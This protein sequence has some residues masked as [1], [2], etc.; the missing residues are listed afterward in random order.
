MKTARL[1]LEDG[2]LLEGKSFG[3]LATRG[4]EVVF[5]TSM[6]GYQ[7][8][9]TDPSYCGQILALTT[10]QVGNVGVNPEDVES[11]SVQATGMIVRDLTEPSNYRSTQSLSAYLHDEGV[12]GISGV[13]TRSLVKH[14]RD[15]G[16]MRGV[17]STETVTSAA[18]LTLAKAIPNMEGQD[19]ATP[20]STKEVYTFS[21]PLRAPSLRN[22]APEQPSARLRIVAYDYGLKR[23]ML[24]ELDVLGCEVT[25]VPAA[26]PAAKTLALQ[27]DGV[28]LTNGPGDPAAVVGAIP[29]VQELLGKVPILGICLGH[30]IL[31]LAAG[32]RTHKMKF[33]HRGGNHP[34]MHLASRRV[35]MTSQ[36]HGF[37]VEESGLPKGVEI[38][39]R[40]LND[41]SIEGIAIPD[42]RAFSVQHHPEASPGPREARSIFAEFVLG[43][44]R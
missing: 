10:S 1:I 44:R 40:N 14:L 36:N 12:P 29:V 43:L 39:H 30:Q 27:P 35:E 17:I 6:Y 32:A 11:G 18:L 20:C 9:L 13:D 26:Y 4:G 25:V 7:E 23:A 34:V 37:A 42:A 22:V 16:V 15:R 2:F 28:L 21:A 19:L 24:E 8:I 41:G 5:N 3:S 38:T 31:A 33:G